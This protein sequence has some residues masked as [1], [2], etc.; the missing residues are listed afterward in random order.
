MPGHCITRLRLVI[1]V[2]FEPDL[3]FVGIRFFDGGHNQVNDS[4]F[5]HGGDQVKDFLLVAR[6]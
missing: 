4:R 5:R 3:E 6:D 2:G 1:Q